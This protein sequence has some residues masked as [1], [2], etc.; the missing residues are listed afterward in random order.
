MRSGSSR[1]PPTRRRK[2][3]RKPATSTAR[4]RARR[5][6][7][8]EGAGAAKLA[9][10]GLARLAARQGRRRARE[11]TLEPILKETD[12]A[13]LGPAYA[14]MG[15]A[16]LS[17]G[18]SE[19]NLELLRDAAIGSFMRVIVQ[20]PPSPSESQDP[21]EWA[22]YG[23]IRAAKRITELER[24]RKSR[25]S[26]TAKDSSALQSSGSFPFVPARSE[27]RR[28][29]QRN[30]R[31]ERRAPVAFSK[32]PVPSTST[33]RHSLPFDFLLEIQ[34]SGS[35]QKPSNHTAP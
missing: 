23:Y 12:P 13:L 30:S 22:I 21:L 26:G 29:A 4:S 6:A 17:Q 2:T 14:A 15:E 20:C 5:R 28:A 7:R 33:S 25:T 16:Q 1:R 32:P 35:R 11:T 24:K 9:N 18:V 3:S 10:I 31:L 19:K 27:G 34:T 8:E